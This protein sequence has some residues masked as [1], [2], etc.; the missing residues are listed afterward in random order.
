MEKWLE[1]DENLDLWHN[2]IGAKDR[3]ILM[4]KFK[5]GRRSLEGAGSVHKIVPKNWLF[6]NS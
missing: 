3:R 1:H 4:N 5:V 6:D 2:K